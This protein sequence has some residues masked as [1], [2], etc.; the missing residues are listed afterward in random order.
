M[1]CTFQVSC[2]RGLKVFWREANKLTRSTFVHGS[3]EY[4]CCEIWPLGQ[5]RTYSERNMAGLFQKL[6]CYV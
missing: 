3:Q 5:G 2:R 6:A 1:S 4:N